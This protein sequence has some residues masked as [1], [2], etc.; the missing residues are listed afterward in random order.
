M[1]PNTNWRE[2]A[3]SRLVTRTKRGRRDVAA[4]TI[5]SEDAA[6]SAALESGAVDVIHGGT[7]RSAVR[8]RNAGYQLI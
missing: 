8:L 7:A 4:L 2:A 6:A 3:G 1:T 5:F